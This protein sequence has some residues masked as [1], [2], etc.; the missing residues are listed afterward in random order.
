MSFERAWKRNTIY[1]KRMRGVRD[2]GE[3]VTE[4]YLKA[5]GHIP[6][7]NTKVILGSDKEGPVFVAKA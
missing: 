7:G 2:T 6:S 3:D 4:Q 1:Y 5:G